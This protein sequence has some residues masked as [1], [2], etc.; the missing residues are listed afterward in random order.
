MAHDNDVLQRCPRASSRSTPLFLS[1]SSA[2]KNEQ[3]KWFDGHSR[4][5]GKLA[6]CRSLTRH[7]A[8]NLWCTVRTVTRSH[9]SLMRARA[10]GR[11][12]LGMAI[13]VTALAYAAGRYSHVILPE[14]AHDLLFN[15]VKSCLHRLAK[16]GRR[17]FT[18]RTTDRLL[19][20]S[21]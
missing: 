3:R 14:N 6:R 15:L 7:M 8:T 4:S 11:R 13:M 1:A 20:K 12:A 5:T 10:G 9:R 21:L 2:W 17:E 18:T 19:W 16:A